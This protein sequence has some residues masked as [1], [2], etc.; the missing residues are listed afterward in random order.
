MLEKII[1]KALKLYWRICL[2][3]FILAIVMCLVVGCLFIRVSNE[4]DR[5][6]ICYQ[7]TFNKRVVSYHPFK[8][9]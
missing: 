4:Q 1:D 6:K 7:N 2:I 8:I 9:R 3:V 5:R